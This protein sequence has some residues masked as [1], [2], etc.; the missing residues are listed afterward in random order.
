[1]VATVNACSSATS[2][3]TTVT[4]NP[5]P[6]TPTISHTTST[7]FC[8]G[9]S[10]TLTSS[11]AAGNQWVVNG[12]AIVGATGQTYLATVAGD[13]AVTVTTSGRSSTSAVTTVAV[14]ALVNNVT[15]TSVTPASGPSSGGQNVT[16]KGSGFESG[17][18]GPNVQFGGAGATNIVV[19]NATAITAKTPAHAKGAVNVTV[20]NIDST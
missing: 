6:P 7:T 13:Y 2:A 10:V 19:V 9:G 18:L 11:S 15:V 3:A 17:P 4:V 8:A 16:I 14:T 1:V 12:S 5:L 20:N